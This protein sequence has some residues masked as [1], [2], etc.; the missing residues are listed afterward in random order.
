MMTYS[1]VRDLFDYDPDTGVLTRKCNIY[2]GKNKIQCHA[3]SVAGTV[4]KSTGYLVLR[5]DG[6]ITSAH[7]VIWLWYYGYLPE[8]DIDHIN[9]IKTDNC[10]NNLR[11]VSRSCN[12]KNTPNPS[13][14]RSGI[15]G[16]SFNKRVGK[17]QSTITGSKNRYHLGYSY[18]Y[19]EAVALRAAAEEALY[20]H[21]CDNM[22]P[23]LEFIQFYAKECNIYNGSPSK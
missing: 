12:R 11:E 20:W 15:K 5:V 4:N 7:R 9:R 1:R 22:T 21:D 14:N 8:T 13:N 16:V 18:D 23:A 2:S 17:W 3:G 10:L 19:T 6:V